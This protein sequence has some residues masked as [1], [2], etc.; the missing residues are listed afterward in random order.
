M[1]ACSRMLARVETADA[2][3]LALELADLA[4]AITMDRFRAHDLQVETKPDLTPVSEA[5]QAVERAIREPGSRRRPVTSC[6]ARSSDRR[7][8]AATTTTE[9]RWIIDPIDGTKSYVRGVPI[10]ATLIGLEP[11]AS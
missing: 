5:D 3:E 9:F 11:R 1:F 7:G 10:W 4:D 8:D 2:L 6:S